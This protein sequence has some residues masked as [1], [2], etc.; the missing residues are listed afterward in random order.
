[1]T[2]VCLAPRAL[3]PD[4]L[5]GVPGEG[6]NTVF[7]WVFDHSLGIFPF[8]EAC[9]DAAGTVFAGSGRRHRG[10]NGRLHDRLEGAEGLSYRG[11]PVTELAEQATFDEVAYLLLH[12]D[13]PTARQLAD[14]QKRWSQR[15]AQFPEPLRD[16]LKAPAARRRRRWMRCAAPSASWP[17]ST[18]TPA[19]S[20]RDGQPAQGGTAARPDPGGHRRAV[21]LQ[22]GRG[23]GRGRGRIWGTPPTSCTCCAARNRAPADARAPGRVADPVRRARVQRLDLHGP[24]GVSR[25]SRTCIRASW[26]PSAR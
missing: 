18:P 10:R 9:H 17:T 25:P 15:P 23:A 22:P 16:L 5:R 21:S 13:L 4:P 26:R 24:R 6:R 2:A 12:G 8:L 3:T 14:F 1:M 19:D 11:Y 20:T 7:P